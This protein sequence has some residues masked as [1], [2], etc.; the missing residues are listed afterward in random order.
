MESLV[1]RAFTA[2]FLPTLRL[3][4]FCCSCLLFFCVYIPGTCFFVFFGLWFCCWFVVSLF[5]IFLFFSVSS[6]GLSLCCAV[7]VA[8]AVC[9]C[10]TRTQRGG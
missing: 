5:C 7:A 6:Y 10:S 8:C 2:F 4:L 9:R 3:C 1:V